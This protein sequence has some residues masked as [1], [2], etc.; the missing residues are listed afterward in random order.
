M[1][2][3]EVSITVDSASIVPMIDKNQTQLIF[4]RHCNYDRKNGKGRKPDN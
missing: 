1:S 3:K 4:Q 2:D